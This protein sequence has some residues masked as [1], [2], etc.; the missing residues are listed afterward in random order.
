[1][2]EGGDSNPNSPL[3]PT[4][5]TQY[6]VVEP[7]G[8]PTDF[9]TPVSVT[10]RARTERVSRWDLRTPTWS[11]SRVSLDVPGI[12]SVGQSLAHNL[13]STLRPGTTT[14]SGFP[15]TN[16]PVTGQY[17]QGPMDHTSIP[18]TH[19]PLLPVNPAPALLPPSHFA[20]GSGT[21]VSIEISRALHRQRRLTECSPEQYEHQLRQE[22]LLENIMR[23]AD[24]MMP[25][26][27]SII[28]IDGVLHPSGLT[29]E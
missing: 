11:A 10:H 26:W 9:R 1:M 29:T 6:S 8:V 23:T 2:P 18:T 3:V 16:G 19:P 25:S 24:P 5:H 15:G 21:T 14:P 4:R 17:I 12:R 7:S 20:P 27:N 28:V 22:L 13:S